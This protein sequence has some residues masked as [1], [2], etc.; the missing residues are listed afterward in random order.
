MR[1][2]RT[3]VPPRPPATFTGYGFKVYNFSP[4]WTQGENEKSESRFRR[5]SFNAFASG[6]SCAEPLAP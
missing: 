4:E 5:S 6:C 3:D 1:V 2:A